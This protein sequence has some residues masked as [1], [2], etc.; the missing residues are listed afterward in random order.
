MAAGAPAGWQV[1]S[2]GVLKAFQLS[3]HP[4]RLQAAINASYCS[5]VTFSSLPILGQPP[6]AATST[7]TITAATITHHRQSSPPPH[8]DH[9]HCD[10]LVY[11]HHPLLSLLPT[12]NVIYVQYRFNSFTI[13]STLTASIASIIRPQLP[14]CASSPI[15]PPPRTTGL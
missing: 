12:I 4:G 10:S 8:I 14:S 1:I 6:R 2:R 15:T 9:S 13:T 11:K 5:Y 7:T 3:G